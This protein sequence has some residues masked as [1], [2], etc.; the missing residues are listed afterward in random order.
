MVTVWGMQLQE[1]QDSI[2]QSLK[3]HHDHARVLWERAVDQ[4]P[5]LGLETPDAEPLA[6][7]YVAALDKEFGSH[8]GQWHGRRPD[9]LVREV[10]DARAVLYEGEGVLWKLFRFV[11]HWNNYHLHHSSIGVVSSVEWTSSDERPKVVFGPS[12]AWRN[13]S[14]WATYRCYGLLV[15]G[16]LRRLSPGRT[17][18]FND[19]FYERGFWFHTVTGAQ[20]KDVGRNDPCPCGSNKKFKHCHRDYVVE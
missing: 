5:E 19:S 11:N 3:R 1:D 20:A 8:G 16:V 10:E 9:E 14:L 7:D 13:A 6:D 18:D 4:H 2:V 17:D 15:L 12:P